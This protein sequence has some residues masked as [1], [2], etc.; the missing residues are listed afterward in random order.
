MQHPDDKRFSCQTIGVQNFQVMRIRPETSKSPK[1]SMY[2]IPFRLA[3][4]QSFLD[5]NFPQIL[6]N[7]QKQNML[8]GSQHRRQPFSLIHVLTSNFYSTGV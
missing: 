2:P 5:A 8:P 7:Q 3:S 1:C 6:T 4:E